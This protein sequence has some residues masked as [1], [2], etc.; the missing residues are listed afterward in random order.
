[1]KKILSGIL[2]GIFVGTAIL[3]FGACIFLII[4]T[5]KRN[6][7]SY[8]DIDAVIIDDKGESDNAE[9][10][11]I[12]MEVSSEMPYG[13]NT[14][15]LKY[16]YNALDS[17][18]KRYLYEKIGESVYSVSESADDSGH[19]RMARLNISGERMSESDIREAV[20]AYIY[21]NPEIFWLENLFG[22]A[23]TEEDTIIEFYAVLSAEECADCIS[24]F[25]K[26]VDGMIGSLQPGLSD[27]ER[28]RILHDG[29]L[30]VCRYK[31]GIESSKDGWQYFS[32]YG[33]IVTGEAVC[34]GYAKAMQ[35]LLSK[36]GVPCLTVRG[37]SDGVSHMWNV[38]EL[39]N[40]WYHLD[41]TWDDNDKDGFI[42]YEYFNLD[43]D[44]I[45]RTHK[46]NADIET[47]RSGEKIDISS[48]ARYNFFVPLCTSM[49][50]NYYNKE[51]IFINEFDGET[52]ARVI[53]A[54]VEKVNEGGHY[55]HIKFGDDMEYSEYVNRMFYQSPY[56]YYYYIDHANELT[57][58]QLSKKS[59]AVLKN[60]KN[61]CLRVKLIIG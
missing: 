45:T 47:I 23:Y 51:G 58:K 5:A 31:S 37:E 14:I 25:N 22:Y 60:E 53:S 12:D 40:E 43:S 57:E 10:N 1:M 34:E 19:Y 3:L 2:Y 50:M 16:A 30:N 61:S 11:D 21:D 52:D 8:G 7:I 29:L 13:Y 48:K 36:A 33:A 56:K 28:E 9:Y 32:A 26:K 6:Q 54:I 39:N 17:E 44:N 42:I 38:V 41:A 55:L 59:I 4:N 24:L 49:N 27:Y 20:N 18:N 46:I 35:I 15:E